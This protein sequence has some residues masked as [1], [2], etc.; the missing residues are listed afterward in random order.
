MVE[1]DQSYHPQIVRTIIA[2]ALR[3]ARKEIKRTIR[4][5][6]KVKVCRVPA[7]EIARMA[8]GLVEA[9]PASSLRKRRHRAL[10]RKKSKGF[11]PR[12]SGSDGLS[13]NETQNI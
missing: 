7:R 10:C 9:N 4:R 2:I 13:L 5:E 11:G 1:A 3:E 12:R 8:E 6:G